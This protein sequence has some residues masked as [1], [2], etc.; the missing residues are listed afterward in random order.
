MGVLLFKLLYE[1]HRKVTIHKKTAKI[2]CVRLIENVTWLTGPLLKVWVQLVH[3]WHFVWAIIS[4]CHP[5]NTS[6][7][8]MMEKIGVLFF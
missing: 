1:C 2:V 8:C 5:T 4:G 3:L 6:F 7:V